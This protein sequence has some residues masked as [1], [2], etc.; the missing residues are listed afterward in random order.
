MTNEAV[1][2]V[3]VKEKT[4]LE[5]IGSTFV[6]IVIIIVAGLIVYFGHFFI[7]SGLLP[8]FRICG[9]IGMLI[10]V[11][12][13]GVAM[14]QTRKVEK[15]PNTPVTCPFCD[16][17]NLFF[18]YPTKDFVCESCSR[19]VHFENGQ[20][21]PVRNIVCQACRTEHRVPMNILR[22]VCDR[23]NRPLKLSADPTQKV[24]AASN[25]QNEA[26]MHNY[27]VLLIGYDRRHETATAMKIQNIMTV[28][29]PDARKI[30]ASAS[31]K[32]PVP[33]SWGEPLRKAEALRRQ[34]EDLGATVSVRP[35]ADGTPTASSS[36]RGT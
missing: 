11:G 13:V 22:Y 19:T 25:A 1:K 4:W 27:D 10:G 28:N 21:I 15:E 32:A 2:V 29:L 20:M 12:I 5:S 31:E 8:V 17:T 26:M 34:F 7:S 16:A 3:E 33:I 35:S 36:K 23:C 24:A 18:G 9:Y 30:L 6:G 14:Y